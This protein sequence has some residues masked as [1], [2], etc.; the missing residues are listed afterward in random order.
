[1]TQP[2]SNEEQPA[3]L[4][5]QNPV[6]APSPVEAVDGLLKK[7]ATFAHL[8]RNKF[9][10]EPLVAAHIACDFHALLLEAVDIQGEEKWI[11]EAAKTITDCVRQ[12]LCRWPSKE[13]DFIEIASGIQTIIEAKYLSAHKATA[14]TKACAERDE[15]IARLEK[16]LKLEGQ[17]SWSAQAERSSLS[18]QLAVMKEALE[19][20]AETIP[21]FEYMLLIDGREIWI[22]DYITKTL[23]NLPAAA[24][25]LLKDRERLENVKEV[26][27]SNLSGENLH[28]LLNKLRCAIDAARKPSA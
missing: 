1:M 27:G 26:I 13:Q 16:D 5:S 15:K 3:S 18:A 19:R 9:G 4:S 28:T 6:S 7:K 11:E 14:I 17:I 21:H 24:E 2:I 25:E 23:S 22:H 8:L 10:I 12:G 20:V